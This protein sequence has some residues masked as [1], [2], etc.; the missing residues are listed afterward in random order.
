MKLRKIGSHLNLEARVTPFD[1][2][3]GQLIDPSTK[4]YW[5]GND[6]TELSPIEERFV[7]YSNKDYPFIIIL[8][9]MFTE[10]RLTSVIQTCL[11]NLMWHQNQTCHQTNSSSLHIHLLIMMSHKQHYLLLITKQ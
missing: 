1:F 8:Y 6:K 9:C 3:T 11:P 10:L 7:N 4:S 2:T 5:I